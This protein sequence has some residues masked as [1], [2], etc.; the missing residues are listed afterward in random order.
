MQLNGTVKIVCISNE[1][2]G[3]R[4]VTVLS[5][6]P[7]RRTWPGFCELDCPEGM[8]ITEKMQIWRHMLKNYPAQ[9]F[10][11]DQKMSSD[12]VRCPNDAELSLPR[13][14]DVEAAVAEAVAESRL[15]QLRQRRN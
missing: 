7:F 6:G 2:D 12:A 9:C 1:P 4:W 10:L 15:R 3:A 5:F 11:D 8:E 13:W 14:E